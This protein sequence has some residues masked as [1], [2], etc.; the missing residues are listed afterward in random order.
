MIRLN[1]WLVSTCVIGLRCSA[2]NMFPDLTFT[3]NVITVKRI[4]GQ[5]CGNRT[6]DVIYQKYPHILKIN[7]STDLTWLL[8]VKMRKGFVWIYVN[9]KCDRMMS[10]NKHNLQNNCNKLNLLKK[11]I[12]MTMYHN[13]TAT[14]IFDTTQASTVGIFQYYVATTELHCHALFIPFPLHC[15]G[16]IKGCID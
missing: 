1:R 8:A 5:I 9:K 13:S 3:H 14:C 15:N 2:V 10:Q 11:W 12:W 4:S 6:D 7:S 16:N